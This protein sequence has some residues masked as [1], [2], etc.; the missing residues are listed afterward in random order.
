MIAQHLSK[1][2]NIPHLSADPPVMN[3][4]NALNIMIPGWD[5]WSNQA[6]SISRDCVSSI[7]LESESRNARTLLKLLCCLGGKCI[8][9]FMLL[10]AR[11]P[12]KIW[13][14]SGE[15][16]E[17][18][19]TAI[20]LNN[21]V[22]SLVSDNFKIDDA[23]KRLEA[24]TLITSTPGPYGRRTLGIDSTTHLHL[25]QCMADRLVWRL[26]ALILVCHTFPMH[27]YAEPL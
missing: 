2:A 18:P 6:A 15:V 12:Q 7:Q 9:E 8:P 19:V 25:S 4:T 1:F 11:E 17:V 21:D 14:P 16:Q 20:G 5:E 3:P 26:Q 13:S 23:I 27:P 22:L 24:A 10:R